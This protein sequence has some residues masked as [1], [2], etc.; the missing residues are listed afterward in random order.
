MLREEEIAWHYGFHR[1]EIHPKV[2]FCSYSENKVEKEATEK[3]LF[4]LGH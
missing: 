3:E 1:K 4:C 2:F